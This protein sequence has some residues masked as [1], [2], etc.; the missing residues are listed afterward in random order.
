[1][2]DSSLSRVVGVLTA[3]EKTF[4]SIRERP[5]WIVALL[6]LIVLGAGSYY[7]IAQ[8]MD[9]AEV[10]R[11]SI[12][13]SGQ[14]MSEDQMEQA[15][16]F[17]E[18]FGQ[19]FSYGAIVLGTPIFYLIGTLVIWV[20]VKLVGAEL[21]FKQNW[22]T[23]VHSQMP[24]AVG[25]LLSVPAILSRE[26][27]AYDDVKTGSI[28]PSNLGAFAPAEASPALVSLLSSIDVFSLWALVLLIIGVAAVG[29][30]KHGTVGIAVGGCW[31]VYVLGKAGW[32]ALFG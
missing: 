20:A 23:F 3:P 8:R 32:A 1:M 10:V 22:A 29:R 18:K 21:S 5:T 9:M 11:D 7:L 24:H 26:E 4:K 6:L 16:E 25:A 27:F 28:L 31:L 13:Q 17:Y 2:S 14:E 19:T 15:I 30:A 12:A